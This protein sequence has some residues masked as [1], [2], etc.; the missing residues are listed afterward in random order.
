V[1]LMAD[2]VT[3]AEVARLTG[4]TPVQVSRIRHRFVEERIQGL[5]DK[6]RSGRAPQLTAAKSARIV[7]LTLKSPPAGLSHWSTRESHAI[8]LDQDARGHHPQSRSPLSLT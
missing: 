7:A 4:Y 2:D 6:P 3:G 8:R 5:V 1:L